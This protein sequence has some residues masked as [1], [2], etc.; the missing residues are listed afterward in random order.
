MRL[1]DPLRVNRIINCYGVLSGLFG[2]ALFPLASSERH[3]ADP[4]ATRT[5]GGPFRGATRFGAVAKLR[6]LD[7]SSSE[8]ESSG[9]LVGIRRWNAHADVVTV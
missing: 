9:L 3:G 5:T 8:G 4:S 1:P 7:L 6:V 2:F